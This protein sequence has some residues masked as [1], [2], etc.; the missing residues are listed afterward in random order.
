MGESIWD[1][2]YVYW[3]CNRKIILN[4]KVEEICRDCRPNFLW[5]KRQCTRILR[6]IRNPVKHLMKCFAKIANRWIQSTIFAE[7]SILDA[8]LG[9]EYLS[10]CLE[11]FSIIINWRFHFESFMSVSNLISILLKCR[12]FPVRY[13]KVKFETSQNF[14]LRNKKGF[15]LVAISSFL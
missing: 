11:A 8:S 7:S 5:N 2:R 4:L 14:T 15:Y 3:I 1:Q 10:D 13:N 6:H 9:S 12:S